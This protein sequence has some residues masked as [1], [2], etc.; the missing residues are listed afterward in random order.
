MDHSKLNFF[1]QI[2]ILV[3][4]FLSKYLHIRKI[5]MALYIKNS[6]KCVPLLPAPD[7]KPRILGLEIEDFFISTFSK[8]SVILTALQYKP[9]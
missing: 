3:D 1:F 2:E 9:Q 7:Y 4:F 6:T 5:Q 8:L